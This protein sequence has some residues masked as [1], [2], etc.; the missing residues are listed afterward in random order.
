MAIP[1]GSGTEVLKHETTAGQHSS[2]Q[3]LLTVP[4]LHI[5]TILSITICNNNSVAGETF[6]LYF[7]DASNS[8]SALYLTKN[9]VLNN[10]ATFIWNDKLVL[11]AGDVLKLITA[12]SSDLMTLTSYIDQ[13]WEN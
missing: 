6:H 3:T 7:E 8:G 11:E 10:N 1:S 12:D 5:C 13:N 9:T 2:A 4:T